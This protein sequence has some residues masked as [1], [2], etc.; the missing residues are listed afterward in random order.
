MIV[1]TIIITRISIIL[2]PEVDIIIFNVVIHHIWFGVIIVL[3]GL[4]IPKKNVSAKI[5]F[6]GVGLGLALD[7]VVFTLL[8]S[9]KDAEYWAWPSSLGTIL[10]TILFFPFRKKVLNF[11][12]NKK[13]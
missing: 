12:L 4:F 6:Y 1:L 3:L 11:L 10:L 2:V 9:G 7:Q 5:L 8:G 13:R